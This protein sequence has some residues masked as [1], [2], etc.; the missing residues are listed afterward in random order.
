[1]KYRTIQVYEGIYQVRKYDETKG[2]DVFDGEIVCQGSRNQC[3]NY[4]V[5]Y[6]IN[7]ETGS[8]G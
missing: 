8:I 2:Q 6:N 4:F 5:M 1:M 3:I 7:N